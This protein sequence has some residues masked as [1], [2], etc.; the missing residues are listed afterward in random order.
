MKSTRNVAETDTEIRAG[1]GIP[2]TH[3]RQS[4]LIDVDKVLDNVEQGQGPGLST[5]PM[6]ITFRVCKAT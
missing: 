1:R 6:A 5:L 3:S 4:I 2:K